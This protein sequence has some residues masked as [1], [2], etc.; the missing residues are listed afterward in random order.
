MNWYKIAQEG[1]KTPKEMDMSYYDIGHCN[2][3]FEICVDE[4]HKIKNSETYLWWWENGELKYKKGD[5]YGEITHM[6]EL[7]ADTL[8]FYQGR[9]QISPDKKIVSIAVPDKQ[10]YRPI[11]EQIIE[12][13]QK[14]FG[15]DIQM[16]RFD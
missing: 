11:P 4:K 6:D 9:A 13:L 12:A 3:N 1:I 14:E 10:V 5:Q 8:K 15:Y 7:G 16:V 2:P